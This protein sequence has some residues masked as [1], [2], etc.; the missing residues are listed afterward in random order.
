MMADVVR[1][2]FLDDEAIFSPLVQRKGQGMIRLMVQ[3]SQTTTVWMVLKPVGKNGISTTNLN[4]WT[5][6]FWTINSR[7]CFFLSICPHPW[8]GSRND[9][10]L[11]GIIQSDSPTGWYA[12]HLIS[13]KGWT[14]HTKFALGNPMTLPE[15]GDGTYIL[16]WGG[17][18]SNTPIIIW[19]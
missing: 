16:C 11:E 9:H 5:P 14:V 19:E 6:D 2:V 12:H 3:K 1:H 8:R 4:W 7:S 15:N 10:L 17:D 18:Y 13:T